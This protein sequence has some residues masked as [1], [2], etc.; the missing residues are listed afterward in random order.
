MP[1]E[2]LKSLPDAE[3]NFKASVTI[4]KLDAFAAQYSDN[5]AAE[6]LRSVRRELYFSIDELQQ[7]QA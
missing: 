4:E 1:Y 5:E 3:Q 6:R 2:K 7:N